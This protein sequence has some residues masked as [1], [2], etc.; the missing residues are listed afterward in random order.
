MG[1]RLLFL[2]GLAL[3][4][5][6]AST[7]QETIPFNTD[8][9]DLFG[10]KTEEIGGR[11][12]Y[13]GLALL[14]EV[15][16]RSGTIEWD[17]WVNGKRSY[18]GIVFH[19][20]P[21]RDYEEFYVRPHKGNGLNADAFQYT[22]V[23]HGV[24]C[25]QLYHGDG[26]TSTAEIP[27]NQW[28]HFKLEVN[29]LRA[30]ISMEG[31]TPQTMLINRLELGEISGRI[32]VKGPADGS[33]WFSNFR[34]QEVK[35]NL[36]AP[37][38]S[39]PAIPGLMLEWEITQPMVNSE[40]DPYRYYTGCAG[41]TWTPVTAESTGLVPLDRFVTRNMLQP[42]WIY[43][44][45]TVKSETTAVHRFHLG[46]SDYITVFI[47]GIPVFTST[48]AYL[49]RDPGFQGLIGFFDELLLPLN[50]GDNEVALLIGEAFGGWG[51]MMRDGE[52]VDSDP[53]LAFVWEIKHQL[54]YPESAVYD[55]ATGLLYVSNFLQGQQEFISQISSDG[56][57]INREWIRGLSKPTGL[58]LSKGMLYAVERTGIAEIDPQK[59]EITSRIVLEGC[60]FPNDI[61][62]NTDGVL[63]ISDNEANRIYQVKDGS[64]IIW[65]EG[66][67]LNKPNGLHIN[68]DQ[69]IVGCSGDPSLKSIDLKS[70]KVTLLAQLYPGAIMDGI[71]PMKD[72]RILFSDFNGHLFILD[73]PGSYREIL[74][75]T[76]IQVNLADFEWIEDNKMLII[77]G[78]YSNRVRAYRLN[79]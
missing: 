56:R 13:A 55:P 6:I 34:Y 2:A 3:S 41:L 53:G 52:A 1:K 66:G 12:A 39:S 9:W 49:S 61:T 36:P 15:Q 4:A 31:G 38:L 20:Q 28:I 14:K 25:W 44:R 27:V 40:T 71:Q 17:I 24:S 51:F 10:G 47:N 54:N 69:L 32:G 46:Y 59:G 72:G 73:K 42:G 45:T 5:S 26:Y 16:F 77:P 18:A 19:Q 64:A 75:T 35:V 21:T 23:Y 74:N 63:F 48:N 62:V 65:M 43:A 30:R 29:G 33:A 70:R 79:L 22:P 50:Q 58:C 57:I 78:L 67:E 60:I 11:Q 76:T 37:L 8:K 68:G 7:G